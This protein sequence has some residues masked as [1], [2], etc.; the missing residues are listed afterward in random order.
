M[1]RPLSRRPTAQLRGCDG[2]RG[3]RRGG[4]GSA[5]PAPGA[6]KVLESLGNHWTGLTVFVEHP[7][8]PMDNNTAE[9]SER[10]PVVGRKNYYGSGSLWSGRLAAMMFSLFQT[11]CL[12][13]LNPRLWLTAYLE[14]CAQA[15]GR[16]SKT[17]TG[18]C[19]GTSA[20]SK[21]GRGDV[22][23]RSRRRTHHS[24]VAWSGSDEEFQSQTPQPAWDAAWDR[25]RAER[26]QAGLPN[27]YNYSLRMR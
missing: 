12:W 14:A 25:V 16:A 21:G 2:L 24:H 4:V 17:W 27:A 22:K 10:G 20:R 3:T 7:E 19:H 15:G 8:V 11:L 5:G 1:T 18:S 26:K 6:R 9:R 23:M 13:G